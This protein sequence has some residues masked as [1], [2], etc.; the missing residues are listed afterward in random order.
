MNYVGLCCSEKPVGGS[1]LQDIAVSG[2]LSV[3]KNLENI[4]FITV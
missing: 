1:E 3:H 4:E 2:F